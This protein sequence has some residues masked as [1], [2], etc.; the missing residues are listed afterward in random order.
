MVLCLPYRSAASTTFL[1]AGQHAQAGDAQFTS[2]DD[3][4]HP[5]LHFGVNRMAAPMENCGHFPPHHRLHVPLDQRD[6]RRAY[7]DFVGQRIHQH[8]EAGD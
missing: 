7:H 1:D 4:D 5:R 8:P 6:E 2:D 3:D